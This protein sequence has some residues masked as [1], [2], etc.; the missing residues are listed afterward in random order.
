M[1]CRDAIVL[2]KRPKNVTLFI[3]PPEDSGFSGENFIKIYKEP[4]QTIISVLN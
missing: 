1:V 2:E 3:P 4:L